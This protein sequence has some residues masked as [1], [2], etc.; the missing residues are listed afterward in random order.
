ML[1]PFFTNRESY[2][3]LVLNV[4]IG[5]LQNC[6]PDPDLGLQV[7]CGRNDRKEASLKLGLRHRN[8]KCQVRQ[9]SI[10]T[11]VVGN[12]PLVIDLLHGYP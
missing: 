1:G 5:E 8:L 3:M 7:Y 12:T 6:T 9:K 10:P 2:P 4:A 11:L